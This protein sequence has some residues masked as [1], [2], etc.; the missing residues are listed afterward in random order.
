MRCLNA[1]H[2]SGFFFFEHPLCTNRQNRVTSGDGSSHKLITLTRKKLTAVRLKLLLMGLKFCPSLTFAV[3]ISVCVCIGVSHIQPTV[4]LNPPHVFTSLFHHQSTAGFQHHL[5]DTMMVSDWFPHS[6]GCF[7][8]LSDESF[9]NSDQ[10]KTFQWFLNTLRMKPKLLWGLTGSAQSSPYS[11]SCLIVSPFPIAV[12]SSYIHP[13]S[14][15]C[16]LLHRMF[17]LC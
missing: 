3:F 2:F 11:V 10:F 12:S 15:Q 13:P 7:S 8:P 17:A 16:S 14:F 4:F 5:L 6:S 1:I 9:Q